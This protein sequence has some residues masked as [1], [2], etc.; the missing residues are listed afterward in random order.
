MQENE[1]QEITK[2]LEKV[3]CFQEND[4]DEE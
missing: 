2:C 4:K 1:T 3:V